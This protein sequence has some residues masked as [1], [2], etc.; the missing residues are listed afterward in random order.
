MAQQNYQGAIR[1]FGTVVAM[2]PLD[3]AGAEY[4]LATAYVAA[5]Q[6][7]KAQDAV[8]ASLEA[9]PDYRPALKLLLELQDAQKGK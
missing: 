8:L 1:E 3:K 6:R 5:G 9:A 2:K 4:Q 7:D